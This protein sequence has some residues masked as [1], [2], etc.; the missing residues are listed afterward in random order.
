MRDYYDLVDRHALAQSW[1]WLSPA[2]Q[3]RLGYGYYQRFWSSVRSVDLLSVV[4]GPGDQAT[5]TIDYHL[6]SGAN[7]TERAVLSFTSAG[8]GGRRL[9]DNTTV[10]S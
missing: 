9:I 5:I 10:V 4:A 7:E 2:Y 3:Q 8:A 1:A 6:A